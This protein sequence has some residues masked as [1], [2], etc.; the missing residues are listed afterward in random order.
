MGE[1]VAAEIGDRELA[2][3]VVEQRGRVLDGVVALHE[4]GGLEAG[5]GEGLHELFERHAELQAQRNRD[6]EVVHQRAEG[7]A[8]LVHV[9]EDFAE[10]AVLVFAGAQVDLV[11]ATTAFWV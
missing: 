8:L 6:R 1:V 4:A 11:A 9:D 2:E 5:E 7:G 10:P 3:H